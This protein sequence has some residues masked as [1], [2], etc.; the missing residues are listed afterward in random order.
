MMCNDICIC[1]FVIYLGRMFGRVLISTCICM[2][3]S[4]LGNGFRPFFHWSSSWCF[5]LH[6]A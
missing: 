5:P 6:V 2:V 4:D 1:G 3:M